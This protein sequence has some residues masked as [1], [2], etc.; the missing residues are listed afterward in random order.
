MRKTLTARQRDILEFI[1]RHLDRNGYPPSIR[2]IGAEFDI[3]SLRGVTVHLD[4]L[5]RKSFIRRD[6]L[7]RGIKVLQPAADPSRGELLPVPI[8]GT[9]AAGIPLLAIENREGEVLVPRSMLGGS[10]SAFALR[11]RG[12][13]M[14]EAHILPDDVVIIRPQQTA[15]D[16]DL[17]AALIGDEATVKRLRLHDGVATLVPANPAYEPIPIRDRDAQ[18]LGKLIGLMRS[19]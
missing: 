7:S 17:V 5:E 12:D 13:S 11:V 16:G 2:E 10:E 18:L 8:L 6:R 3:R 9:I 15:D 19:Y 14:V 4:A 1:I